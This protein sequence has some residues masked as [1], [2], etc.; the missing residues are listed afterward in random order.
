MESV[1]C[2]GFQC[3]SDLCNDDQSLVLLFHHPQKKPVPTHSLRVCRSARQPLYSLDCP[4]LDVSCK[5]NHATLCSCVWLLALSRVFPR[6]VRGVAGVGRRTSVLFIAE[7]HSVVWRDHVL[8]SH[9]SVGVST[10]AVCKSLR[11][12]G[13]MPLFLSVCT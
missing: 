5:W 4:I 8:L 13:R 11:G 6:R 2:D 10:T 7:Q 12:R 1:Q 9:S 3:L